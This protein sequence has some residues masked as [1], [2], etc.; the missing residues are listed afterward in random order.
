[1][2]VIGDEAIGRM[3]QSETEAGAFLDLEAGIAQLRQPGFDQGERSSE[4]A[5]EIRGRQMHL[6][7]A[8]SG[9]EARIEK[10]HVISS[11]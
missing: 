1:V 2:Q 4:L 11:E 6:R 5:G 9:K 8:Q 7:C 10:V 3:Q